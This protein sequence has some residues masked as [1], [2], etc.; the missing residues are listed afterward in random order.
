MTLQKPNQI[1]SAVHPCASGSRFVHPLTSRR[2]F[3]LHATMSQMAPSS[4]FLLVRQSSTSRFRQLSRRVRGRM[5]SATDFAALVAASSFLSA[6]RLITAQ[7][8][9]GVRSRTS[10]TMTETPN[11]A[12]QRIRHERRSCS[13]RVP[14]AG[15]AELGSLG[16]SE[17]YR[18]GNSSKNSPIRS[19]AILI[20]ASDVA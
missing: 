8:E 4:T 17:S 15:S 18:F 12:L 13:P 7:A 19:M 3:E 10:D 14:Q 16:R 6:P 1:A 11:H 20:C 5:S 9:S 2:S